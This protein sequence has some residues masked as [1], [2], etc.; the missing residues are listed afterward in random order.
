MRLSSIFIILI[1]CLG[2]ACWT[3][4][5]NGI[6]SDMILTAFGGDSSR[7]YAG[8]FGAIFASNDQGTH[9]TRLGELSPSARVNSILV[10]QNQVL[11]ATTDG[12]F[13]S[14]NQGQS[15]Q[16]SNR[17]ITLINPND[18]NSYP[19]VNQLALSNQ[20][21]FAAALTG[22]YCSD[23][24]GQ[25]WYLCSPLPHG[26]NGLEIVPAE[27]V[28][29]HNDGSIWAGMQQNGV[30][31]S[32]DAGVTWVNQSAGLDLRVVLAASHLKSCGQYLYLSDQGRVFYKNVANQ[33]NWTEHP[34]E[35]RSMMIDMTC[36][37]NRIWFGLHSTDRGLNGP[38]W[39]D[40]FIADVGGGALDS[41]D[42]GF[43]GQIGGLFLLGDQ[44]YVGGSKG[45]QVTDAYP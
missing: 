41:L 19:S 4:K 24:F 35:E 1:L 11:L 21:V 8:G 14:S 44:L 32:H 6:P 34:L 33:S 28:T 7:L 43:S 20:K 12:I 38:T 5:N 3:S 2:S 37:A 10:K 17:G 39:K 29:V 16:K 9:W 26:G 15:F 31:Q 18:P 40:V 25:N 30:Y 22:L 27:G 13:Y 23:Q 42:S 36:D 45:V